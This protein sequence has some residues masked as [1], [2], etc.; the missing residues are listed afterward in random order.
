MKAAPVVALIKAVEAEKLTDT[1]VI[2]TA[3]GP[4]VKSKL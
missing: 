1:E 3:D 2:M 4:G